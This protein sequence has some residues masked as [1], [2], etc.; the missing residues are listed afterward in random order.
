MWVWGSSLAQGARGGLSARWGLQSPLGTSRPKWGGGLGL[1][2][3]CCP[4]GL[5]RTGA[6]LGVFCPKR[7]AVGWEHGWGRGVWDGGG[8]GSQ[9]LSGAPLVSVLGS[10][11]L[12]V[13][14]LL[15]AELHVW[16][17]MLSGAPRCPLSAPRP[18]G[19]G[20]QLRPGACGGVRPSLLAPSRRLSVPQARHGRA[21]HAGGAAAVPGA[22]TCSSC[23]RRARRSSW[24]SWRWWAWPPNRCTSAA[25]RR[26]C[27]SGRPTRGSSASRCRPCPSAASRSSSCPTGAGANRS[28]TGTPAPARLRGKGGEARGRPP[29][30]APRSP[31][32]SCRR[33]GC[34]RGRVGAPPNRRAVGM[35]SRALLPSRRGA[36][37]SRRAAMRWSRSWCGRWRRASS[38][39]CRAAPGGGTRS[40]G[41]C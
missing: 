20:V 19:G 40:C 17:W 8:G 33:R 27:E 2:G 6:A 12:W 1:L 34:R 30:A 29:P 41:L 39:C 24:R 26:H 37:S 15:R 4:R 35:R 18:K 10:V 16:L 23:A 31:R 11:Q 28:A 9:L 5:G 21:P 13:R 32:R 25:C 14:G 22:A 36:P 38:G 7:C 3:R